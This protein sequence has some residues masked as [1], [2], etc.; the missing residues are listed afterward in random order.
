MKTKIKKVKKS[1]KKIFAVW[2]IFV[3][4]FGQVMTVFALEVPQAPSAP[5]AP[6]APSAPSAPTP[7][8]SPTPPSSPSVSSSPANGNIGNESQSIQAGQQ[9]NASPNSSSSDNSSA[10]SKKDKSSNSSNLL[11]NDNNTSNQQPSSNSPATFVNDNA[12]GGQVSNENSGNTEI[13][14][15]DATS[16][17]VGAVIANSNFSASPLVSA[18]G[19]AIVVNNGNGSSSSNSG[20][21][22]SDTS[23][24]TIQ[25]NKASVVNTVI[26]DTDTGSNSASKNLGDVKITTGNANTTGTIITSV[27]TNVDGVILAEF[28]VEDDHVGNILLDFGNFCLT[29]CQSV[30]NIANSKNGANS[31]NNASLN[32][33]S[34]TNTFQSNDAVVLN[35]LTLDSNTGKNYADKNTGGD[36]TIATGDANVSANALTFVNNNIAGNVIYGVV[37]IFG[38][39]IGDIIA[40]A[41]FGLPCC[42]GDTNIKNNGNGASSV[43]NANAIANAS[44][45]IY[46]FNNASINNNLFFDANT[47]ENE[48]SKNTD[49]TN[50]VNSGSANITAQVVNIANTNIVGGDW[51]L[52]LINQ[53]GNWMG[54][55]VGAPV[56][57]GSNLAGSNGLEFV[58]DENGEVYVSNDGNG[59]DSTNNAS[60][61]Q[62]NNNTISQTNTA[63]ITNNLNL[64]ANTGKNQA[65][66]NTGGNT[67]ITTGDANIVANLVNFV[68]N[69]IVGTGRLFVTVVNVFGSWVGNFVSPD[70]K[71]YISSVNSSTDSYGRG[72]VSASS[73]G[74]FGVSNQTNLNAKDTDETVEKSNADR[75]VSSNKPKS[76]NTRRS[77]I[78]VL[79][80]SSNLDSEVSVQLQGLNP[81]VQGAEIK[82]EKRNINI[83]LAWLLL[84]IPVFAGIVIFKNK[85]AIFAFFARK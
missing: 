50:T 56:G 25:E 8:P 45:Q 65:N 41:G 19:G 40:P 35:T 44:D 77:N 55:I 72:G 66:K 81:I 58:V 37:N 73:S 46:Q 30:A 17:A 78:S 21:F 59:A 14:T 60:T 9:G 26:Q 13:K 85:S 5:V 1:F 74:N 15:A 76:N 61:Y 24:N 52:V 7:P 75:V 36:V 71:D 20:A 32:Q 10:K 23:S 67:N 57:S 33:S 42:L 39:L 70:A 22:I 62:S 68:N 80:S 79:A 51:W 69:N 29:N 54:R 28:N 34:N 64:T 82:N 18:S 2:V 84:L 38:N 4:L 48:V 27:N 47:G 16:N 12:T 49:G 83:N 53:A 6:P 11:A 63:N 43:N 3:L 31:T